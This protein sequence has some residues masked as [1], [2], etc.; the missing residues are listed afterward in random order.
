MHNN[1]IIAIIII[2]IIII[3]IILLLF[4]LLL[5]LPI[6]FQVP[7]LMSLRSRGNQCLMF[8]LQNLGF[9][10]GVGIMLLIAVYEEKIKISNE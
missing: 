6:L 2:V 8:L 4:Q 1:V 9:F 5:L 3:I 10:V 7:E